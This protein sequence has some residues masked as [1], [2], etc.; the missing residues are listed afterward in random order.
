MSIVV[1][2]KCDE[3]FSKVRDAFI[4]NFE[5]RGDVG[6]ALCIYHEGNIVVDLWG[7]YRNAERTIP[8]TPDTLVQ[9]Y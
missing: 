8:W 7:G 5:N 2:G 9:T 6:A 1:E 4:E 3:K